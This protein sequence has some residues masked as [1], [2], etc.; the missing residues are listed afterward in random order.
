MVNMSPQELQKKFLLGKEME[1]PKE[2]TP[3]NI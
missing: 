2:T 1:H 3:R